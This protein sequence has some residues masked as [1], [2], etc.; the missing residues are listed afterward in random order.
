MLNR[1]MSDGPLGKLLDIG[2]KPEPLGRTL[3]SQAGKG[4]P[5]LPMLPAVTFVTFCIG[6]PG[7]W[8]YSWQNSGKSE[9]KGNSQSTLPTGHFLPVLEPV[10]EVCDMLGRGRH[11][12]FEMEVAVKHN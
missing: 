1:C 2:L 7:L 8:R 12:S 3:G 10:K 5:V 6:K 4:L 11:N 9:G